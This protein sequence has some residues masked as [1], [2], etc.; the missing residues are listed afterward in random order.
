M[1]KAAARSRPPVTDSERVSVIIASIKAAYEAIVDLCECIEA[2]EKRAKLL[3][4]AKSP[5]L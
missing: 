3:A 4:G 5:R 2:I 1:Q